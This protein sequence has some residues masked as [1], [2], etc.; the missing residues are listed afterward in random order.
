[1]TRVL[2]E[3]ILKQEPKGPALTKEDVLT[4]RAL[5]AAQKMEL[6]QQIDQTKPLPEVRTKTIELGVPLLTPSWDIV[7]F[8]MLVV[9]IEHFLLLFKI[10]LEIIITD[11]PK[12]VLDGKREIARLTDAFHQKRTLANNRFKRRAVVIDMSKKRVM[13]QGDCEIGVRQERDRY[14]LD[15]SEIKAQDIHVTEEEYIDMSPEMIHS[16][17]CELDYER[18]LK[19]EQRA[20]ELSSSKDVIKKKR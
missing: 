13:E 2:N 12:E 19:F 14:I 15:M 11:V 4:N 20:R 7:K 1:M 16:L 6:L 18:Q 9:I 3:T 17:K 10:F 8:F 5:S